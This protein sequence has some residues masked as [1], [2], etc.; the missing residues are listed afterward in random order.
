[1]TL[2]AGELWLE[3]P[4]FSALDTVARRTSPFVLWPVG[5]RPLLAHWMDEAVRRNVA[6]VC[7]IAEDRPHL[8]RA[9]LGGGGYWSRKITVLSQR[10]ANAPSTI[11]RMT[12]L[13]GTPD[14]AAPTDSAGLLRHW[15]ALQ[16]QWVGS[17]AEGRVS[18]ESMVAPGIWLG[19]KTRIHPTAKLTAPCW[20]GTHTEIGANSQIGPGAAVGDHCVI[21]DGASVEDGAVLPGTYV[22][23]R[24]NLRHMIA[25]GAVLLDAARGSRVDITDRFVLA[26]LRDDRTTPNLSER[27]IAAGFWCAG[28]LASVFHSGGPRTTRRVVRPGGMDFPLTTG[29]RGPLIVRRR[30]W[31]WSVAAGN[32]RLIGVL[33][34]SKEEM[35]VHPA[36]VQAVLRAASCGVVSLADER[37]CH[38]VDHPEEWLHALYQAGNNDREGQASLRRA[39]WRILWSTPT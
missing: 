29:S 32:L 9:E 13:P 5:P 23:A 25:D 33:P 28:L 3:A 16:L 17:L 30:P 7:I 15:L 11:E 37:G 26:P 18:I 31:L 2:P 39:V 36:D 35:A 4:D 10:P 6:A 8:V 38:G 1:M 14:A 20:I 12:G 21:D 22:G 24:L 34:R 27:S 19:V